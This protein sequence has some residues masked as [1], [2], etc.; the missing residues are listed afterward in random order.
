MI[1]SSPNYPS[2]QDLGEISEW[3][4]SSRPLATAKIPST[5]AGECPI[6]GIAPAIA[7]GIFDATGERRRAMPLEG[8]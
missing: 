4:P 5:G 6:V 8:I 1:W 3:I 2:S 7:A